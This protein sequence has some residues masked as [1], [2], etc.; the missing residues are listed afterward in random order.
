MTEDS[1]NE[2]RAAGSRSVDALV[3][4]WWVTDRLPTPEEAE[5][6]V[7]E[8]QYAVPC[9]ECDGWTYEGL[10]RIE[11]EHLPW[12]T[13]TE[14]VKLEN[15]GMSAPPAPETRYV[16][17]VYWSQHWGTWYARWNDG[18]VEP[19]RDSAEA[20]RVAKTWKINFSANAEMRDAADQN[21]RKKL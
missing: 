14:A 20:D 12:Q 15:K 11:A 7:I 3:R 17:D 10:S 2:T 8:G 16:D 1:K 6:Y 21:P 9:E 4:E 13:I 18:Q 5:Y 19:L